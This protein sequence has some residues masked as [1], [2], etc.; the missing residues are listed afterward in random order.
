MREVSSPTMQ[1]LYFI[2]GLLAIASTALAAPAARC[3]PAKGSTTGIESLLQRRL[4]QHAE[5][6]EFSIV[7][8]TS[9]GENDVYSVSNGENGKIKVEGSSLSALA[10]GYVSFVL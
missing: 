3:T 10:T 5:N 7:N 6:F 9:L 2:C 4:P 8:A 1:I